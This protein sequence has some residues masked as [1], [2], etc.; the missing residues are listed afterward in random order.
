MSCKDLTDVSICDNSASDNEIEI[1][2]RAFQYCEKLE[3]V[4]IGNGNVKIGE[5]A[6]SSCAD[7]LS[8]S[9]AGKS[10][11]AKELEKGLK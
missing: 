8:V 1:D 6:F 2:D 4:K 3:S 7:K 10:Y 9:A 5:Y 11:T